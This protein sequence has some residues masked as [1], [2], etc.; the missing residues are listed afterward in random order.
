MPRKR[1][2][3]PKNIQNGAIT[4]TEPVNKMPKVINDTSFSD[5]PSGVAHSAEVIFSTD[6]EDRLTDWETEDEVCHALLS[7][8]NSDPAS[9]RE[10][11]RSNERESWKRAIQDELE[12]M[13]KN[14]GS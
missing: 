13:S 11:M 7:K 14:Q 6:R 1:G 5:I 9:F 4:E 3:P 8:I 2:R 12:S 10:A